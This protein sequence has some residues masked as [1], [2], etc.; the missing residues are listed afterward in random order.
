MSLRLARRFWVVVP[1]LDERCADDDAPLEF[2]CVDD[3][4]D[5]GGEDVRDDLSKPD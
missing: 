4:D 2:C 1:A 5:G 3:A